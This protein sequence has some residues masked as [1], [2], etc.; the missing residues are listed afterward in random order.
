[1]NGILKAIIIG[2]TISSL[3]GS[4]VLSLISDG[5]MKEIAKFTIGLFIANALFTPL[6]HMKF[7]SFQNVFNPNNSKIQSEIQTAKDE[8]KQ[9]IENLSSDSLKNHILKQLTEK[10][11]TCKIEI[12]TSV[13]DDNTVNLDKVYV[14]SDS[15]DSEFS[16][17]CEFIQSNYGISKEN[18]KHVEG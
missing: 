8:S 13:N 17:I 9:I 16:K 4:I 1:M 18:I 15:N 10:G 6:A 2:V 7:P 14:Y 3:F 5:V 11:Y 12:E